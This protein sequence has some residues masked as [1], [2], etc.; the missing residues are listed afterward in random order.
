MYKTEKVFNQMYTF[1]NWLL[2]IYINDLA[3]S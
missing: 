3:D 2:F 1:C